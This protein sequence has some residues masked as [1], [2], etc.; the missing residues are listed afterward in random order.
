[1]RALGFILLFVGIALLAGDYQFKL[2]TTYA[3]LEYQE[4]IEEAIEDGEST[5]NIDQPDLDPTRLDLFFAIVDC[6]GT[7]TIAGAMILGMGLIAGSVSRAIAKHAMS[8]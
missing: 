6:G 4:E 8:T 2:R 7:L 1:M 3:Q 5:A